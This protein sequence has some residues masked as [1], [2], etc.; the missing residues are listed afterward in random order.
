MDIKTRKSHS[1]CVY[2]RYY[3][4]YGGLD[5]SE[6][7]INEISWINMECRKPRWKYFNLPGR[8]NHRMVVV[9]PENGKDFLC[10]FGGRD[11]MSEIV[12]TMFFVP[13]S[14]YEGELALREATEIKHDILP[15]EMP[16][17][18]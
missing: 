8:F 12:S 6:E 15:R 3:L 10:L 14:I 4:V 5:E 11:K 16:I 13:L 17:M 2:S 7:I 9:E 18:G 1:A